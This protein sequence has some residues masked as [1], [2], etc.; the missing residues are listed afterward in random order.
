MTDIVL[1]V[2]LGAASFQR[3]LETVSPEIAARVREWPGK[4]VI[5]ESVAYIPLR[6][7]GLPP[8]DRRTSGG[9]ELLLAGKWPGEVQ[10]AIAAGQFARVSG[11]IVAEFWEKISSIATCGL[12]EKCDEEHGEAPTVA[13][14]CVAD[15]HI[16]PSNPV[17]IREAADSPVEDIHSPREMDQ[18][19]PAARSLSD[20]IRLPYVGGW[21][22]SHVISE[23]RRWAKHYPDPIP[24]DNTLTE[25]EARDLLKTILSHPDVIAEEHRQQQAEDRAVVEYRDARTIQYAIDVGVDLPDPT[26]PSMQQEFDC[27]DDGNGTRMIV[28]YRDSIRYCDTFG[29]WYLWT[30][31][32]WERDET[33]R[34]LALA[35]RVA[36]TIYIEAAHAPGDRRERVGKWA[37]ASGMISRLKAMIESASPVVA[38]TPDDLDAHPALLNC[39]NCTLDLESLTPR[40]PRREDLLTKMAGVTY[41]PAATCPRWLAHLDLIFGG[42]AEVIDGFQQMAGYSLFDGNPEQVMFILYG[43]G[44]NGKSVTLRVLSEVLGDYAVNVAAES[45]M[46]KRNDAIRSDL[47]RLKGARLATSAEGGEGAALDEGV[48]KSLTGHEDKITVARKYENEFEFFPTAKIWFATNHAP[49]IRG[50]DDGIWRR[51]W[52][53]PFE[54]QIGEEQ[55]DPRITEK[56]LDERSGIL[57]WMLD[58][59]RRYYAQGGRLEP[60]E[61]VIAATRDYRRESDIVGRYLADEMVADP[62]GTIERSALYKIY[63]KWCEE[64][65]EKPVSNRSV[66][67]YLRDKGFPERKMAGAW[68][69]EGLRVKSRDEEANDEAAGSV[70][71]ML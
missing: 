37:V 27:T 44:K 35:K 7:D 63:V 11:R 16:L 15:N 55:R 39:Q 5:V 30:G 66:I 25:S 59:L 17:G 46:V 61:K 50:T 68:N 2:P 40:E 12:S 21:T 47:A 69:W 31:Q 64:E 57:N 18:T 4:A 42:D 3:A 58:G 14:E 60:P 41:D 38:V 29:A 19:V 49:K 23:I 13:P 71:G 8:K 9:V 45:L 33:R 48:V 52:L 36:R 34:M 53:I 1:A 20:P 6:T 26:P 32:R 54:V 67:K 65:N 43:R 56:L 22:W 51:I 24:D 62:L 10:A 28:Q 70:Q